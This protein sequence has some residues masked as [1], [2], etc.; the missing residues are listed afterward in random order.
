VLNA[1]MLAA[2][3]PALLFMTKAGIIN[4]EACSILP[5]AVLSMDAS[6]RYLPPALAFRLLP[7]APM[8]LFGRL[9]V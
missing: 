2:K 5:L 1:K 9:Q 8:E 6:T 4:V 3:L 7:L